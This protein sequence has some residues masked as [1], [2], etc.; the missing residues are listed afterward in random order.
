[1]HG[2]A[3][4]ELLTKVGFER[5]KIGSGE[6]E[7]GYQIKES[8]LS[9]LLGSA[10]VCFLVMGL[11]VVSMVFDIHFEKK[12]IH[13]QLRVEEHHAASK[14]AQVQMELW[15]EF[16]SDIK[17][18]HE[19]QLLLK[20]MNDSYGQLQG[21]IKAAVQELSAELSL[22]PVK[23]EKFA[24]KLLHIVADIQQDNTKHA[25]HLVDHLVAAGKRSVKL[26]KHI[27][28]EMLKEAK[29]EK[30]NMAEDKRDGIDVAAPPPK[31][32]DKE[33]KQETKGATKTKFEE[34]LEEQDPLKEMIQ[35]FFFTFNDFESEFKGE[36][37]QKMKEGNVIYDQ[38]AKL[39][40]E[41]NAKD[42]TL[43][44]EDVQ[45]KLNKIDLTSVG[46]GLG[47]G[48]VLPVLDIVEEIYLIPKI[49]HKKLNELEK[50]WKKGD[51]DSVEVF[52]QLQEMHENGLVPS[53]WL[54]MGVGQ[55]EREEEQ[56]EERM[57][58]EDGAPSTD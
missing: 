15:S 51:A 48:R 2:S 32:H 26:E 19:A 17:E 30:K 58:R 1:M 11:M 44:E 53:G 16:H 55:E 39:Y 4:P 22:N 37:R 10:C 24:D 45:E 52:E 23:T 20:N 7:H 12:T 8:S 21:K 34:D 41:I 27:D 50:K 6:K 56:D 38:I 5:S 54:Q 40:G 29:E 28:K 18:S 36:A 14:L 43:S 42:S 35:G 57:E 33:A 49:P 47:S 31:E 46:A 9:S 25:K 3:A 13:R